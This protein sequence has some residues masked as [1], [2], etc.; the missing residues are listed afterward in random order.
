LERIIEGNFILTGCSHAWSRD[1]FDVFGP[2]LIPLNCE[3]MVIPFRSALL[4]DIIYIDDIL[5]KYRRHEE[6]TFQM[7]SHN[8][9]RRARFSA[10]EDVAIFRNW[11]K[12]LN[13]FVDVRPSEANRIAFFRKRISERLKLA[14]QDILLFNSSWLKRAIVLITNLFNGMP[15]RTVKHR[16][17]IFLIPQLYQKYLQLKQR[18]VF[19]K[20]WKKS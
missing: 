1:V 3:D 20:D 17:G 4:G 18:Q 5:I 10:G 7:G 19:F 9:L 2:L 13:R 14:N 11:L 12:D 16:I 8:L 15:L 6:N